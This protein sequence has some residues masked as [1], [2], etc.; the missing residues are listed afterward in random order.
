MNYIQSVKDQYENYPYPPRNES[1]LLLSSTDILE[2][3]NHYLFKGKQTF[4]GF[5][6]LVAGCGTGDSVV[7]L[8]LQLKPLNGK[9]VAIDIS[10]A[11]LDICRKRVKYFG[12]DNITFLNMS[13]LDLPVSGFEQFDYINCIGV[14]HHLSNPTEGLKAL[15]SVL[16]PEG[17][18]GLMVYGKYGRLGIYNMQDAMRLINRNIIDP[19]KKV[20][21][22]K[23]ILSNLPPRN[24]FQFQ[25]TWFNDAATDNGLYDMFLHSND[26]PFTV[27]GVYEMV[28]ACDMHI[29]EFDNA[30]RYKLEY[31]PHAHLIQHLSQR[32]KYHLAE[33][34]M[35]TMYKHVLYISN[36]KNSVAT[37]SDDIIPYFPIQIENKKIVSSLRSLIEKGYMSAT[38]GLQHPCGD[39]IQLTLVLGKYLPDIL[40]KI[41]GN[42]T[43]KDIFSEID[44][45]RNILA[46]IFIRMYKLFNDF[47]MMLLRDISSPKLDYIATYDLHNPSG[48]I[49]A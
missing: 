3:V 9:V 29:V 41:D 26:I 8:G 44:A 37:I 46:D 49:L 34:L 38:I 4:V 31:S 2:R 15:K 39:A 30:H 1:D 36:I 17:G 20:D 23:D 48:I 28:E 25:K 10:E 5:R 12:L 13:L 47:S 32:E 18:M 22:V 40:E 14:L 7:W 33:L 19:Q 6:A 35:G 42:T 16:K 24:W 21:N 43:I 45:P 11:S 27:D